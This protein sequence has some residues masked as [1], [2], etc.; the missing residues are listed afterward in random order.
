MYPAHPSRLTALARSSAA[1]RPQLS[2][3][4]KFCI[5]YLHTLPWCICSDT[6]MTGSHSCQDNAVDICILKVR[7]DLQDV[8]EGT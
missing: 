6:H 5:S 7:S 3:R 2:E 4:L 1:C 8:Q